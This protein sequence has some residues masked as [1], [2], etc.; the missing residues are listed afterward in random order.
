MTGTPEKTPGYVAYVTMAERPTNITAESWRLIDE[1]ERADWEAVA[2]AV[3]DPLEREIAD[4]RALLDGIG[5]MAAN[6]PED[7]DSFGLLEEIAMRVAAAGVPDSTP[8][9]E[10]PDPENPVTG[11]TPGSKEGD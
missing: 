7:G 8:A 2:Q 4:L 3:R 6:A 9:G 11:R 1:N 5:V 10:W